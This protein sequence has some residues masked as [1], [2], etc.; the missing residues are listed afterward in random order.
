MERLI[1]A[2]VRQHFAS[3][4]RFNL[5][6]SAYRRHH[7]TE[8]SLLRTMDAAHRSADR[9][10]AIS[11]ATFDISPAFWHCRSFSSSE[12]FAQQFWRRRNALLWISLYLSGRSQSVHVGLASSTSSSCSFGVPQGSVLG[13]ILFTVYTSPF[14]V[15]TDAHHVNQQQYADDT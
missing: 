12:P 4:P 3:S 11:I 9:G 10:E 15:V 2:N 6:Q 8:T 13:P 14:A 5:A 1:L 7:S